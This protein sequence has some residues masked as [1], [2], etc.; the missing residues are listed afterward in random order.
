M[1]NKLNIKPTLVLTVITT[2]IAALL[3][4]ASINLKPDENVLSEQILEKCVSLMGEGEYQMIPDWLEAG[5]KIEKP[6]EIEKLILK[7]DG[8]LAFQLT[9]DGYSKGGLN[10]LI[11]M[12]PDGSVKGVSIISIGETP[13]LGTKVNDNAFLEKF[14][15]VNNSVTIVKS[16]PKNNSEV[17]AVT[18]ATYSSKG[19]AKG[20]NL[21]LNTFK[22]M[23][24]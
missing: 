14:I 20:I 16:A 6:K 5:Y 3:I 19:V 22:A 18:G 23:G 4:I 1:Q 21:A 8:T 24:G 11:A 9:A 2:I 13:G 12:N 10:M 15:G 7:D 17:Q